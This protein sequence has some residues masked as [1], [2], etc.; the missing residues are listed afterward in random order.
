M[1]VRRELAQSHHEHKLEMSRVKHAESQLEAQV[2]RLE[3]QL[4][5]ANAHRATPHEAEQLRSQ[6]AIVREDLQVS[7]LA[8]K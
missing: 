1:Q 4:Q 7:Q 2:K 6:M 3:Q 5:E 8:Y